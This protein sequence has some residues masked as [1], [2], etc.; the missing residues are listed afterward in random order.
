MVHAFVFFLTFSKATVPTSNKSRAFIVDFMQLQPQ[1]EVTTLTSPAVDN[2]VQNNVNK[3]DV[4]EETAAKASDL[5]PQPTNIK[6]SDNLTSLP[7]AVTEPTYYAFNELDGIPTVLENI[8][9][10]PPELLD[11]PQSGTLKIQL[12]VDE[13]GSVLRA[14]VLESDLPAQFTENAKMAFLKVKFSPGLKNNVPVRSM[15]KIVMHYTPL[16]KP[17]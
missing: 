1:G 11:Y 6:A 3:T 2:V 13:T 5:D 12:W 14:E 17:I 9:A 15:T 8:E 10:N 4:V 16:D 7:L